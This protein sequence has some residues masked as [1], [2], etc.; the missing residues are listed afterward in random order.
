MSNATH[1]TVVREVIASTASGDQV[2]SALPGLVRRL[3]DEDAWREFPAPGVAE[4]V[5]HQ[6]FTEFI[7][8]APPRGL[9]GRASQLVALCGKDDELADRVR[10]LLLGEVRVI[11]VHGNGPGRGHTEKRDCDTKSFGAGTDTSEYVVAR[12]KR[13]DPDL[14]EQVIRGEV[15]PNAAAR[16]KGWRKPR[17]ILSS[18]EKTAESIRKH[19]PAEARQALARL[20]MED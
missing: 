8:D 11:A 3:L 9:G 19:M 17:I 4:L 12:L 2:M 16:A 14:A 18:P 1:G 20:L 7:S 10:T 6:T 13:D 5:R 15:T